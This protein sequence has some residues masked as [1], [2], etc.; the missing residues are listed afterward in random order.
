MS[1]AID[2]LIRSRR[3]TIAVIVEQDGKVTVR[4]PL[5]LSE[6][7]IQEFVESHEKWI[8]K[9]KTRIEAVPKPLFRQYKEGEVFSYLGKTYSLKVVDHQ[10]PALLFTGVHFQIATSALPKAKESFSKWY[11]KQAAVVL[12]ERVQKYAQ[13]YGYRYHKVRISSA[14][15][16]WGS[17]SSNG[18]LSFTY[19][20][21]MAPL[22]VVDYVVMHELVHTKIRNHSKTFWNRVEEHMPDY[23]LYLLWLKK[24]GKNFLID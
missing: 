7:K 14:R 5:R 12:S 1:I 6:K 8:I 4:A 19:R 15:T 23:K 18:T 11:R 21:V 20:L 17:C 2:R 3:R 16:R 10:R 9:N 13:I 22:E 24:H